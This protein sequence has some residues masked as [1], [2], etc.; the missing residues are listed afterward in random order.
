M[1]VHSCGTPAIKR[2]VL[3]EQTLGSANG[4]IEGGNALFDVGLLDGE[5]GAALAKRIQQALGDGNGGYVLH[6]ELHHPLG[7]P[8]GGPPRRP[9]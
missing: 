1:M 6:H 8:P 9:A 7:G 5:Q 4:L 2:L 3:R